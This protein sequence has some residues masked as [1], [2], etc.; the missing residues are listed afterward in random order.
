MFNQLNADCPQPTESRF[1]SGRGNCSDTSHALRRH[2][3][4]DSFTASES[5]ITSE[6]VQ[7]AIYEARTGAQK[8]IRQL[9]SEIAT[10]KA[11]CGILFVAFVAL[12]L[13]LVTKFQGVNRYAEE[14]NAFARGASL[15]IYNLQQDYIHGYLQDT[16]LTNSVWQ[17]EHRVEQ[18]ENGLPSYETPSEE[19]SAPN[20]SAYVLAWCESGQPKWLPES[21]NPTDARIVSKDSGETISVVGPE[22]AFE[23]KVAPDVDRQGLE[24]A[25]KSITRDRQVKYQI[26]CHADPYEG[27]WYELRGLMLDGV[28]IWTAES[29]A[30]EA[31]E[32]KIQTT[33][34]TPTA[35][36][37]STQTTITATPQPH[38]YTVKTMSVKYPG[39]WEINF[40]AKYVE[41]IASRR[42]I[43]EGDWAYDPNYPNSYYPGP[44]FLVATCNPGD[45]DLQDIKKV[46]TDNALQGNAVTFEYI[47]H[48]RRFLV[49]IVGSPSWK[50]CDSWMEKEAWRLDW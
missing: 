29:V 39:E 36:P 43:N 37:A 27:M 17:L 22:V 44:F 45:S 32:K 20:T 9:Q 46:L 24:E 18:I 15:D 14:V 7:T 31:P 23:A 28:V 11:I 1:C 12:V 42:Y 8:A 34:R 4:K 26:I 21:G 2:K 35:M 16:I 50:V 30:T 19:S 40:H 48:A 5:R 3:V 13:V 25:V 10:L 49:G 33:P 38:E 6:P 47:G 41:Q